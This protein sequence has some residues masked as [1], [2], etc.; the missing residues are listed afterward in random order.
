MEEPGRKSII[1]HYE[2]RASTSEGANS[3]N[4]DASSG[5]PAKA[6]F[7]LKRTLEWI[8]SPRVVVFTRRLVGDNTLGAV[9][10][11][12]CRKNLHP[13]AQM[14]YRYVAGPQEPRADI[15]RPFLRACEGRGNTIGSNAP[16][17]A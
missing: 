6:Y 15:G 11:F 9:R 1:K 3:A 12:Q 2:F 7:C 8:V 17:R 4:N 10:E 13:E 5:K 14:L 16:M